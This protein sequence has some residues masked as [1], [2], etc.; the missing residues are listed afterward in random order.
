MRGTPLIVVTA[1]QD[2]ALSLNIKNK[3]VSTDISVLPNVI[4]NFSRSH[5]IIKQFNPNYLRV[6][7]KDIH[8]KLPIHLQYIKKECVK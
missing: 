7:I 6:N 3:N 8:F 2:I 1:I 4:E 5:Y